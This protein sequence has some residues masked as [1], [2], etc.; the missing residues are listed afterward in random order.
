[1]D[2]FVPHQSNVRII[3]AAAEKLGVPFER[4]MVNIDRVGNMSAASVP[5]ALDELVRR[6]DLDTGDLVVLSGYGAGM[7]QAAVAIRWLRAP[8]SEVNNV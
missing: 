1:M 5:V 7:T 4:F 6:G 2:W 3:F 8:V